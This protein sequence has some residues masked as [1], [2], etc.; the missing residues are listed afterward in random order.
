VIVVNAWGRPDWN[1]AARQEAQFWGLIDNDCVELGQPPV[2]VAMGTH[3]ARRES[4]ILSVVTLNL[5]LRN[6][7]CKAKSTDHGLGT[8]WV[9]S[10]LVLARHKHTRSSGLDR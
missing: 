6:S 5:L 3:M 7:A 8:G 2:A 4:P 10:S 1:P 9:F